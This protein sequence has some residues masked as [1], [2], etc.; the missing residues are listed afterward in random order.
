MNFAVTASVLSLLVTIAS[1]P[2]IS[3]NAGDAN[4]DRPQRPL[5]A[6]ASGSPIAIAGGPDDVVVGDMNKDGKLDLVIASG[7]SRTLEVLPG[8]GDG[9]FRSD[10]VNKIT[11]SEG[12]G[13]M[14][15]GDV[16]SDGNL[17]LAFISHDSYGVTM[18]LGDGKGALALA[19]NSPIVMKQ[20]QQ[21]HT[22]GL[23]LGDLNGDGKLDLA[24]VNSTD[25]D[26]SVA[27]GDGRGGFARAPATFAVGPSPYPMALGDVNGDGHLDIIAT[28]TATGPLRA[29]QLPFSRALTLLLNDGRGSFRVSHI[30]LRTGEP[31]SVAIGDVN[32]DKHR[33]LVVT[34]HDMANLTVLSGDSRGA[35]TEVSGSPFDFGHNAFPVTLADVNHD[36]K[37][38]VITASG[39]G[40]SMML[41]DGR[42]S[43]KRSPSLTFPTGRGTWNFAVADLNGDGKVDLVACSGESNTVSVLLG[44]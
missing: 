17:D 39:E 13:E 21:P 16:N 29:Q 15:L 7:R 20:G 30:P 36:G 1:I 37:Q 35:F 24:T 43:F 6:H 32:G 9:R 18:L 44:Q 14:A 2:S 34:H 8:L 19:P 12:P 41:G 11:V 25:N 31:W 28:A 3:C 38:D 5:F 42:G 22:H 40:V 23:G 26:V 27:F 10:A 4:V 33:D